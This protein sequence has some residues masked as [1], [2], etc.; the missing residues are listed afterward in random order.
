MGWWNNFFH[1]SYIGRSYA[2]NR[3]GP[4]NLLA[5]GPNRREPE[6]PTKGRTAAFAGVLVFLRSWDFALQVKIKLSERLYRELFYFD[7]RF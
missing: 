1:K 7:L 4:G 6:A 3:R 5:G 2:E